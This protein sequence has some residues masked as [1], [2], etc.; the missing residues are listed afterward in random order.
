MIKLGTGDWG[1]SLVRDG[2]TPES[3]GFW[4]LSA[5]WDGFSPWLTPARGR[6]G[7]SSLVPLWL[8]RRSVT[9][10][11]RLGDSTARGG[12]VIAPP[13]PSS[14][15]SVSYN[16]IEEIRV[17]LSAFPLTLMLFCSVLHLTPLLEN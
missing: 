6:G 3:L 4:E 17:V 12:L 15:P 9:G 1:G 7:G 5:G 13:L 14:I 11:R 2:G 16:K 10:S 8:P